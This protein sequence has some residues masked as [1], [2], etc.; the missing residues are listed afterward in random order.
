MAI[1]TKNHKWYEGKS[2]RV[3]V[4]VVGRGGGCNNPSPPERERVKTRIYHVSPI[5]QSNF[6][7]FFS[8]FKVSNLS[9]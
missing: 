5:L 3:V 6:V 9:S 1:L 4:V 7:Y 2:E 8:T